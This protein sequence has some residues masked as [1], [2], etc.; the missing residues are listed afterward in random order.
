KRDE[1]LS[2]E[3]VRALLIAAA[4]SSRRKLRRLCERYKDRVAA[5]VD[6]MTRVPEDLRTDP[7]AIDRYVQCLGSVAHCLTTECHAAELWN[8]LCGTPED[9]PLLQW[10]RWYGEL[11]QRMERLEYDEL[12][13]EARSFIERAKSLQG[14]A[15]RQNEAF[16]QG[17]LGELLFHAG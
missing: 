7:A 6:V 5:N 12:I 14:N 1:E 9:N 11:R 10:E 16:L 8:K 3:D 15:A 4:S 17:R 2:T 13:A